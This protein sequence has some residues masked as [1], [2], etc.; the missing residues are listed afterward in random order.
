MA[1]E[2]FDTPEIS[3]E[4]STDCPKLTESIDYLEFAVEEKNYQQRRA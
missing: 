3:E 2:R 1:V 4:L